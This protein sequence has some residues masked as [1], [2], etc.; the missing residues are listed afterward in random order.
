MKTRV[1]ILALFAGLCLPVISQ[2]SSV[3]ARN[4]T[5]VS[6]RRVLLISIDG[7]HGLDLATFVRS[8]PDSALAQLSSSGVTYTEAF[9]FK[10]FS[11]LT[12]F[13]YRRLP[14]FDWRSVR[15]RLRAIPFAPGLE[16]QHGRHRSHLEQCP[17]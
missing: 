2:I 10:L 9:T 12:V 14:D 6:V 5:F 13:S 7:L 15:G 1:P 17:G 4:S 3:N 8:H 11:G 16:L